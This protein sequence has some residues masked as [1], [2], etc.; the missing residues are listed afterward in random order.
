MVIVFRGKAAKS[1]WEMDGWIDG[2]MDE[3][4][5]GWVDEW[6]NG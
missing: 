6:M 4:M 5:S 3:W 2:L 1:D